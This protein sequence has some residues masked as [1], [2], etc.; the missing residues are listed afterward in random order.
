MVIN[1]VGNLILNPYASS[2]STNKKV[3]F[4]SIYIGHIVIQN[5]RKFSDFESSLL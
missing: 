5:D 2:D 4:A 1:T 3:Y